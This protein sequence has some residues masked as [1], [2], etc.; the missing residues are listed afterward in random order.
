MPVSMSNS[1]YIERSPQDVFDYVTQPWLWH[2]WHPNSKSAQ[3]NVEILQLHDEFDEVIE[4]QPL[5]P[6]PPIITRHTHYRVMESQVGERWAVRGE[7]NNGWLEIRYRFT[8]EGSG[9]YFV[10]DLSFDT[11]GL[12]RMFMPFLCKQMIHVSELALGNLKRKLESH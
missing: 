8:Q 9:C 1:I 6:L 4:L 5:K 7:A 3:S 12:L 2:Q 10:R 11:T